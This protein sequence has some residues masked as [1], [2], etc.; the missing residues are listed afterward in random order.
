M[1][2]IKRMANECLKLIMSERP[3]GK[4]EQIRR[5]YITGFLDARRL[6]IEPRA[7]AEQANSLDALL[8]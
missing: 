3:R 1:E 5:A 6:E 4:S 8:K 2:M 7:I